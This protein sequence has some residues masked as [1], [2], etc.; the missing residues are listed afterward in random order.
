MQNIAVIVLLI[1]CF[2]VLVALFVI[3]Y[4]M[5]IKVRTEERAENVGKAPQRR[6]H[7]KLKELER[8]KQ[9]QEQQEK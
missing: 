5:L 6:L 4:K 9:A 2:V 8:E 1:I 7:P 3:S